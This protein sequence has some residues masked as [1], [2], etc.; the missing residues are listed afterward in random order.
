MSDNSKIEWTDATWNP[1]RARNKASGGVGHFCEHVSEGC[2]NCYAERLQARFGNPIR[3]AR[4]DREKVELFLDEEKLLEPLRWRKPRMI[5]ACSMTD[6]FGEWAPDEWLDKVFAVMALA[7]QHTFQVLT[8]RPKRM[9]AWLSIARAHPVGLQALGVTLAEHARDPKSEI[10]SGVILQGDVCH[11]RLWPLHN[12]W[13]GVSVED[14]PT[15]DE[16]IP[17]LLATPAALRWVSAEPLLAAID[18]RQ[19]SHDYGCSCGWGGDSPLDYCNNCGWRGEAPIVATSMGDH[20][21][22]CPSCSE[23]LADYNACPECDRHDGDGLS[24]GPNDLPK[25][26]W[27]VAGGE[28]GLGARPTRP[29]WMRSIRDQ[30]AAAGVAFFLKQWGE[31]T[32]GENVD[33]RGTLETASYFAGRWFFSRERERESESAHVDDEPHLYRVG[34]HRAGRLLDGVEHNAMP[35]EASDA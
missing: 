4:Q 23:E 29:A 21:G 2:R 34:K 13:L 7:P 1:I 3:Y 17:D 26:N 24:S 15:A 28:S 14:Q 25:L 10:G 18:I 11:L 6:L 33:A 35:K 12:V 19:W 31:W 20:V 9:R 5:F 8:K 27:V 30:C 22:A 32:P 16:R